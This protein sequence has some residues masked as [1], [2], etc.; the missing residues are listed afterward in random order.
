MNEPRDAGVP[1]TFRTDGNVA[2]HVPDLEKAEAFS[3]V[4]DWNGDR[5][6]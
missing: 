5:S 2:I 3:P 1:V 4:G 6:V